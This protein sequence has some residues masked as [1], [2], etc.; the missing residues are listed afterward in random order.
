[1]GA[2][3]VS[4]H[5]L[6]VVARIARSVDLLTSIYFVDEI[7]FHLGLAE[8]TEIDAFIGMIGYE[9]QTDLI[10]QLSGIES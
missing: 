4:R 7:T 10:Y 2:V 3:R 9:A 8:S 1:M 6:S 5:G